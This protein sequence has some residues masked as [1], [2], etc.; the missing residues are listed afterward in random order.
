MQAR[1]VLITV[2]TFAT[3]TL[4]GC[5][6]YTVASVGSYAVTGKGIGDH[7][8]SLA[9]GGDCNLIKHT[10]NGQYVCEM[11]VVYNRSAF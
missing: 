9:S 4:N 7:A 2:L 10:I 8:G 5:A 11:P 1:S 3:I 6:V